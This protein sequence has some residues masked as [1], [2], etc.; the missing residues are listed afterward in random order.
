[1]R[2]DVR[3]PDREVGIP[4][5]ILDSSH[6]WP[7]VHWASGRRMMMV[8][9]DFTAENVHGEVEATRGQVIGFSEALLVQ[10]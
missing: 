6:L 8:P 4:R 7:V 1:M 9:V 3:R 10:V 5:H 2:R